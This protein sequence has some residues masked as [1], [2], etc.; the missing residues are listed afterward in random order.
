M[1][2]SILYEGRLSNQLILLYHIY[3]IHN[4]IDK[5][6]APNF[7]NYEKYFNIDKL[8]SD[9]YYN[10]NKESFLRHDWGDISHIS[11]YCDE[12]FYDLKL[13]KEYDDKVQKILKDYEQYENLISVH[14]RQTDFKTWHNGMYHF[15]YDMYMKKCY[16]KIEEWGIENFKILIFSDTKQNVTD[17]NSVFISDKTDFQGPVDLFIMSNCNYFISTWSTF[18]LMAINISGG[19]KKF[20]K[21]Y[22]LSND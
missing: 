8:C 21:N 4:D 12:K 2:Y 14:I 7:K 9:E 16:E 18:S 1:N 19:L 11:N 6:Y 22:I 10:I 13:K 15:D 20:K 17:E 5:I 3:N